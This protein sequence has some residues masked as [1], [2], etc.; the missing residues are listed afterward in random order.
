MEIIVPHHV[1]SYL[2]TGSGVDGF[3]VQRKV[4]HLPIDDRFVRQDLT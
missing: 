2:R 1:M 4:L 3:D